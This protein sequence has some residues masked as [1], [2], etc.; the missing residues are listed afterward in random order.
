[1]RLLRFRT[2]GM[3]RLA[4]ALAVN[5]GLTQHPQLRASFVS[6]CGCGIGGVNHSGARVRK[7]ERGSMFAR[8]ASPLGEKVEHDRQNEH[9]AF[10]HLLVV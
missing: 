3:G 5:C 1:M 9:N 7:G 10:D 8:S 2:R 4:R 6:C